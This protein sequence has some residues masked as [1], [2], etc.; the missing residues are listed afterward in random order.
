MIK[1]FLI[2]IAL[3]ALSL[4]SHAQVTASTLKWSSVST[5]YTSTGE[6]SSED[7]YLITHPVPGPRKIVWYESSGAVRKTFQI[8][9]VI[10][11]WNNTASEGA[12]F[13]EVSDMQFSGTISI[14]RKDGQTKVDIVMGEGNEN[15]K[16]TIESVEQL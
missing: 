8:I 15:V 2:P 12:I 4:T 7:T 6:S 9:D 11:E 3:F 13:Y 14:S 16:L 1:N 10:G 5:L